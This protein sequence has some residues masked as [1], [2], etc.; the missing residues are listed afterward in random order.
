MLYGDSQRPGPR[1]F[2]VPTELVFASGATIKVVADLQAVADA[3]ES[4]RTLLDSNRFAGFRGDEVVA[5]ERIVVNLVAIA[6]AGAI[7]AP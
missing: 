6:H 1:R 2:D 7:S 4:G 5:A 3:L